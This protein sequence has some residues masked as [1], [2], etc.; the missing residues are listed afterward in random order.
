ME[1]VIGVPVAKTTPLSPPLTCW[2]WHTHKELCGLYRTGGRT[3]AGHVVVGGDEGEVLE[4]V[5]LV[6]IELVEAQ[7]LEGERV[8]R[9]GGEL[10]EVLLDLLALLGEVFDRGRVAFGV[11]VDSRGVFVELLLEQLLLH[12]LGVREQAVLVVREDDAVVLVGLDLV[13]EHVTVLRGEICFGGEE[14]VGARIHLLVL[15]RY[16]LDVGLHAQEQ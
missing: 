7:L 4:L 13:E 1:L 9:F 8:V 15:L 6:D 11:G 10:L 2:I 16:L 3:Q 14:D 12:L 5:A